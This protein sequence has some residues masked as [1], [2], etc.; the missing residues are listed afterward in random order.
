[1][2]ISACMLTSSPRPSC[3]ADSSAALRATAPV[4][5]SGYVWPCSAPLQPLLPLPFPAPPLLVMY[6][7]QLTFHN[8]LSC[9][10]SYSP[11]R[12]P[13]PFLTALCPFGHVCCFDTGFECLLHRWDRYILCFLKGPKSLQYIFLGFYGMCHSCAIRK[14]VNV[15]IDYR[16][17]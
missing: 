5:S 10:I 11:P 12:F 3:T 4:R 17:N 16:M 13:Y 9:P 6:S 8:S 14:L 2:A 7:A 15:R 1:M